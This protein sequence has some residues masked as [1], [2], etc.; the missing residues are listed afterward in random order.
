MASYE[1]NLTK[2]QQKKKKANAGHAREKAK[3]LVDT[4]YKMESKI[5]LK[6]R[7]D[8]EADLQAG[9]V[10]GKARACDGSWWRS[11]S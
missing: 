3:G 2:R 5:Q 10:V 8:F 1:R 7:Q 4:T 9:R 6:A 11:M